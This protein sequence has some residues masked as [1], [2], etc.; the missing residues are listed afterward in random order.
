MDQK[1]TGYIYETYA[2]VT[3]MKHEVSEDGLMCLSGI[4]GQVGVRNRNHRVYEKANYGKCVDVLKEEIKKNGGVPGE[5]E[6]PNSMNITLEN[7]SHK[8]T[9]IKMN[10]DG[11]ITGTIKL[12][13]TPKGKI[14]QSIVEGGLPL[15]ISSRGSGQVDSKGNVMLESIKTYDLVGSPGFANAQMKLTEGQVLENLGD[16]TWV[17]AENTEEPIKENNE[18]ESDMNEE[19]N[20]ALR[21]A[22]EKMDILEARIAELEEANKDL[23]EAL[24]DNTKQIADGVQKWMTDEFAPTLEDWLQDEF[25]EDVLEEARQ[26]AQEAIEESLENAEDHIAEGVQKWVTEEYSDA[27]QDWMINEFAPGIQNWIVE[28]YSPSVEGWIQ[29]HYGQDVKDMIDTT[30]KENLKES[31]EDKMKSIK[32]TLALLEG[33]KAQKPAL[34]SRVVTESAGQPLYIQNM[35]DALRPKYNMAPKEVKESIARRAKLYNLVT[36]AAVA[37]FWESVDF[38]KLAPTQQVNES[39]LNNVE[40]IYERNIRAMFRRHRG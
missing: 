8:I 10:E 39:A 32:D 36:E 12:L 40:D 15:Y 16:N 30:I 37:R 17:I 14:A 23:N 6:H 19:M 11:T 20:E 38:D 2:P 3:E 13:N 29:E 33:F 24:K 35:P 34:S 5:L 21:D 26:E 28:E 4:F 25:R 22:L 9:D 27:V 31:S 7:I 1:I 18:I